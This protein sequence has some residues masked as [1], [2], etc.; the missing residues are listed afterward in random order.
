[1]SAKNLAAAVYGM[2][3]QFDS[4]GV[5]SM[6]VALL[7]RVH[8][9]RMFDEHGVANVLYGLH[10]VGDNEEVRQFFL[11]LIPYM[12]SSPAR[13]SPL[14]T[15]LALYGLRGHSSTRTVRSILDIL[16]PR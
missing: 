5:R 2:K 7:P 14:A 4:P 8:G 16:S 10:E 6:L 1:M 9:D 15:S 11:R 12:E 3:G 13:F